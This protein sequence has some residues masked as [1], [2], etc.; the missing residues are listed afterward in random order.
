MKEM[1]ETQVQSLCREDPLEE[2][3]AI[4]TSILARQRPWTEEPG[5]LQSMKSQPSHLLLSPSPSAL[6]LSQHQGL[7]QRVDSSHPVAIVLELQ[8][9]SFQ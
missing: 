7:F 1:Q 2:G 3:M 5:W 4:H 9:Q 8:H 6:N